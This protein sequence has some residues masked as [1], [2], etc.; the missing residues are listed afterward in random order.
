LAD[1][2]VAWK[3]IKHPEGIV[4]KSCIQNIKPLPKIDGIEDYGDKAQFLMQVCIT[5]QKHFGSE[6]FF[7]SLRQ[8]EKVC[9]FHFTHASTFLQ[10]FV[11]EGWIDIVEKETSTKARRYRLKFDGWEGLIN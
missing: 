1:F 11:D 10:A 3:K 9:S 2:R 8:A 4:L 5:L 6:P 7:L